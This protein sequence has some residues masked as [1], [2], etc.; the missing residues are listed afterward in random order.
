MILTKEEQVKFEEAVRPLMKHLAENYHPH[1][2][3]IV[4]GG[5]AEILESSVR[6]VIDDYI[7]D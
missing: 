6:I 5:S 3:V 4:E 2:T 7:P 1:V